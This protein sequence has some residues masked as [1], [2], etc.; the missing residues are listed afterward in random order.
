[1]TGPSRHLTEIEIA[2]SLLPGA[3]RPSCEVAGC[4][5]CAARLDEAQAAARAFHDRVLPRSLPQ[6]RARREAASRWWRMPHWLAGP[7][8]FAAAAVIAVAVWP[9][10]GGVSPPG[11]GSDPAPYIG[12]KGGIPGLRVF[13]RRG[14]A[15]RELVDGS[16]V[17]PGDAIR[18]VVDPRGG[19]Y[20]V[21][22]SSGVYPVAPPEG[23]YALIVS[24]DGAGHTSVY[25]PFDGTASAPLPASSAPI[26]LDGSVVLDDVLGNERLWALLSAEPLQ[27]EQIRP[28]LARLAGQGNAAIAA[29]GSLALTAGLPGV[30][31]TTLRLAKQPRGTSEAPVPSPRQ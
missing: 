19:Q 21:D 27:V 15:V 25:Y 16:A 5:A 4:T 1:M 28:Q 17:E 12:H 11:A 22:P 8:V 3:P 6:L 31:A 20:P 18:F 26:E 13:A 9:R 14:G 2:G 24:I 10:A 23:R 30:R 7:L 29:A